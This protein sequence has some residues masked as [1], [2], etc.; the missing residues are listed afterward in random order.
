VDDCG[1]AGRL[2]F[3]ACHM[4]SDDKLLEKPEVFGELLQDGSTLNQEEIAEKYNRV[5]GTKAEGKKTFKL[6]LK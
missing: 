3:S 2:N 6:V 5:P 1:L 4:A